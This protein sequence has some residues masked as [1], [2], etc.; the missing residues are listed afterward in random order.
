[1]AAFIGLYRGRTISDAELVALSADPQI[2]Q[3][4]LAELLGEEQKHEDTR[5]LEPVRGAD[6]D[7][8]E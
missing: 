5:R 2:V 7:R 4:F 3:K 6:D 8:R 1:M